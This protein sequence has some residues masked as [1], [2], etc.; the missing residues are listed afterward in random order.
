[1]GGAVED[2]RE[3][4]RAP[5]R[6]GRVV[7]ASLLVFL[8]AILT[9]RL[10]LD[11]ETAQGQAVILVVAGPLVFLLVAA[12]LGWIAGAVLAT[13]FFGGVLAFRLV[14][15]STEVGWPP[16]LLLPVVAFSLALAVRVARRMGRPTEAPPEAEEE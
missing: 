6:T 8:A 16:L 3:A 9:A 7:A 15:V 1:M 13:L 10:L 14:L 11:A 4:Y 12:F 5:G 2:R